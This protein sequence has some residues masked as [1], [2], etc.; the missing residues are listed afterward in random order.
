MGFCF[1][2]NIPRNIGWEVQANEIIVTNPNVTV[3]MFEY[4]IREFRHQTVFMISIFF[5]NTI[6]DLLPILICTVL[7]IYLI[8]LTIRFIKERI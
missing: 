5:A 8:I 2:V 7:N 6:P 3:E 1:V 4:G